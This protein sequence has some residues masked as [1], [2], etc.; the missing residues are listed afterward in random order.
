MLPIN[1]CFSTPQQDIVLCTLNARYIHSA[2]GLRYLKANLGE[3]AERCELIEYTLDARPEDI[4]EEL[5]ARQPLVVGFG[6][7]IWNVVQTLKVISLLKTVSPE[8]K[9]V[10]GGPE[11]SYEQQGQEII[12][13]SDYVITGWGEVSF[14]Q[15]VGE[16]LQGSEPPERIIAGVQP[17]LDQIAMPYHLYT[18]DDI[19]NRLLY[20]EASRGCPFKCEF[21][22]SALDKTA[23][24]FDLELFLAEMDT[25]YQRGARHFKFVDRTFNLKIKNS[26]RILDFFLERLSDDLFLHFEVVP[27]HLPNAL[28]QAITKF[29]AGTLQFEI[30]IQ[31]FNPEVQQRISRRQDNTKAQENMCWIREH[32]DAYIHA[33]LIFGLP[34]ETLDSFANSFDQLFALRPHEIQV[35]ILKRL[36]GSPIVRH[37]DAHQL[38]F[39]PNPPFSI[40]SS[41]TVSFA[42]VQQIGRFAR[43]WDLVGNSGRFKNTLPLLVNDKPFE[44][45]SRLAEAI[46]QRT[47]Q[48]HK[49]SLLRLFDLVYQIGV[50]SFSVAPQALKSAATL[51][52]QASGLKSMPKCLGRDGV[53]KKTLNIDAKVG[54][55]NSTRQS[56]HT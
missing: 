19:A 41:D 50:E 26:L 52:H 35:G 38:R 6:V 40:V 48:T 22:L 31:T 39:N 12:A 46:Y 29:P 28:K 37:T 55:N 47:G 2:F 8:T 53:A 18:E 9:V 32:S 1:A 42:D 44:Q 34:G 11:V 33:D 16:L 15:L 7:Y 43:Y 3:L 23:W 49:I 17:K 4:V 51:D 56:R 10:L 24:P 27:D 14:A 25:L 45:F 21:C 36:K 20:V 13:L 30:G 5:L 54:K